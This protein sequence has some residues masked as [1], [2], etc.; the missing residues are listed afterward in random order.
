MKSPM[1]W[2]PRQT[3]RQ[4]LCTVLQII[5][6]QYMDLQTLQNKCIILQFPPPLHLPLHPQLLPTS[7]WRILAQQKNTL[8]SLT[9]T[10]TRPRDP[11]RRSPGSPG[12]P[13]NLRSSRSS[14]RPGGGGGGASCF[15]LEKI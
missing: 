3:H 10:T 1:Q 12:R 11:T 8:Q 6:E 4:N 15:P 13:R 7:S 2:R 5:Q 14:P 9:I